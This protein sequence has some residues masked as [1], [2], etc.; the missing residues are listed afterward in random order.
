MHRVPDKVEWKEV[1]K[2]GDVKDPD[3]FIDVEEE[4]DLP[5]SSWEFAVVFVFAVTQKISV[6]LFGY[7]RVSM[8]TI[9]P[10]NLFN[11]WYDPHLF[12]HSFFNIKM[13]SSSQIIILNLK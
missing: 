9:T 7:K 10:K 5:T 4:S 1:E 12:C 13:S 6:V 3:T 8:H 11:I 2:D